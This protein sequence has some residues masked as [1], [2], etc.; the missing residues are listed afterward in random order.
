M[1]G[2][3][4]SSGDMDEV[5]LHWQ[6]RRRPSEDFNQLAEC[7]AVASIGCAMRVRDNEVTWLVW[8]LFAW[9]TSACDA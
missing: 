2:V 9:Q 1:A 5:N 8:S 7:A 4:L 6:T 3:Y